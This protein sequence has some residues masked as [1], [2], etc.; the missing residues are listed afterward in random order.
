MYNRNIKQRVNKV[1]PFLEYDKDPYL[2]SANG[3]LYWILDAYTTTNRYPYSEPTRGMGNYIRNSVK[4]VI[5]AFHGDMNLYVLDEKDPLIQTY[6]KIFPDLFVDGDKMPESIKKHIRYPED[7][8]KIQS[9]MYKTYHMQNP[10]VFYNKEDL[11]DIPNENYAGTSIQMQPYY[12]ISQLPGVEKAEFIL[13]LPFTPS[14]KNNMIAWMAARS[15]GD[16]YGE[17]VVYNFPKDTLVYGPRQIESRIDQDSDISQLLTLWSQR[18]SRVIRG[19]LLVIPLENSVIYVEPIYLQAEESELPEMKRVVVA[20]QDE[21][22]MRQNFDQAL[23]E[24]FS[25]DKTQTKKPTVRQK[26]LLLPEDIKELSQEAYRVY[27]QTQENL[28]KGNWDQYG[29]SLQQLENILKKIRNL[30]QEN[31]K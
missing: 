24:I 22:V 17:L 21:I 8:F 31:V 13:M 10:T 12:I 2:V 29:E 6:Q 20:Y 9:Q 4:I 26:D 30:S 16:N 5:D 19:N 14:T 28:K 23:S 11:W 27:Q 25:E 1:A 18:G 7:L 15:D 3:R